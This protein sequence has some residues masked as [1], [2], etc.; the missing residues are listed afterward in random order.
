MLQ[1]KYGLKVFQ[2]IHARRMTKGAQR[3][4]SSYPIGALF[5]KLQRLQQRAAL[6]GHFWI[7]LLENVYMK[8]KEV[9]IWYVQSGVRKTDCDNVECMESADK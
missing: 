7:I 5:L 9:I 3:N 1:L 4:L 6:V 2:K 8:F